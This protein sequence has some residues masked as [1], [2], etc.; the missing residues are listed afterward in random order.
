[1]QQAAKICII[2]S[3]LIW[4]C[5][6]I[7]HTRILKFN[8]LHDAPI[9]R[10]SLNHT[11]FPTTLFIGSLPAGT[12]LFHGRDHLP[13]PSV[14]FFALEDIYSVA[15]VGGSPL[16]IYRTGRRLKL[17]YID[18]NSVHR[19]TLSYLVSFGKHR[20][21]MDDFLMAETFCERFSPFVDG[22]VR[23]SADIE[24]ILCRTQ[25]QLELIESLPSLDFRN[26]ST[27]DPSGGVKSLMFHYQM[28]AWQLDQPRFSLDLV[29]YLPV[30]DKVLP[31]NYSF[32]H[33]NATLLTDSIMKWLQ[34]PRPLELF[35]YSDQLWMRMHRTQRVLYA[36]FKVILALWDGGRYEV[37]LTHTR[38][39]R[40]VECRYPTELMQAFL[41][42]PCLAMERAVKENDIQILRQFLLDSNWALINNCGDRNPLE[43]CGVD[44]KPFPFPA[45]AVKG[46]ADL[47]FQ[48]NR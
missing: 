31:N 46:D 12:L 44:L 43:T 9:Q 15:A 6:S 30:L 29:N 17:I 33:I 23:R 20:V 28:S 21:P 19:N 48:Y 3:T 45:L 34:V 14:E 27:T 32:S 40:A 7:N 16:F 22:M 47:S 13:L 26:L 18:G 35:E 37:A 5:L 41:I 36:A 2:L 10:K 1:M 38:A 8:L 39:L 4:S 24:L 25:E 11:T 42:D